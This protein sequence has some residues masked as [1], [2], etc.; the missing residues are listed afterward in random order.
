MTQVKRGT[1]VAVITRKMQQKTWLK[2]AVVCLAMIGLAVFLYQQAPMLS[3]RNGSI[4]ATAKRLH[5]QQHGGVDHEKD[6]NKTGASEAKKNGS[7]T[8]AETISSA[9]KEKE[10]RSPDKQTAT[11]QEDGGRLYELNLSNLKN[12][13]TGTTRLPIRTRGSIRLR[14]PHRV[15]RAYS[16]AATIQS[17]KS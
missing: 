15:C 5:G 14:E 7:S 13:S 4:R 12:G 16:T 6:D 3:S 17:A 2:A 10:A 8:S 9:D 11:K 1:Q